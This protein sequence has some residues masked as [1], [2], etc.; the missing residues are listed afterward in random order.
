MPIQY[1]QQ[2]D[3]VIEH[4]KITSFFLSLFNK[5]FRSSSHFDLYIGDERLRN[6]ASQF[7]GEF[8]PDVSRTISPKRKS[9]T[10]FRSTSPNFRNHPRTL[11][12]S[13]IY[14]CRRNARLP[15]CTFSHLRD[16][17]FVLDRWAS[18]PEDSPRS[19]SDRKSAFSCRGRSRPRRFFM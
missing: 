3:L 14:T 5:E 19:A 16:Q 17:V 18:H 12:A 10:R 11:R 8:T 9:V 6:S 7:R 2:H 13:H 4:R 15:A 1:E